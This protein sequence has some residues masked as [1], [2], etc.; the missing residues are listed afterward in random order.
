MDKSATDIGLVQDIR[1]L[2]KLRQLSTGND[3]NQQKALEAAARQFEAIFNQMW[4]GS[5]REANDTLAPDSPLNSRDS[6]FFQGMLDEQRTA[7]MS[8]P[9]SKSSLAQLIVKQL[10]PRQA[11]QAGQTTLETARTLHMPTERVPVVPRFARWQGQ[12]GIANNAGT[13]SANVDGNSRTSGSSSANSALHFERR[14]PTNN[15]NVPAGVAAAERFVAQMDRLQQSGQGSV[16]SQG[17][18]FGSP[19]AFVR[20]LLP[21]AQQVAAKIGLSPVA[22]LAQAALET[23]WGRKMIRDNDGQSANNLFGIKA[24]QR[25][26]GK[27]AQATSLEYE[28]GQPVMRASAF[29]SYDSF[30]QSMEDYVSLIG[31]DARYSQARAV[32]HDPDAYF[33]AL[34]RAGYATDPQYASKLK[35]VLRS[36]AFSGVWPQAAL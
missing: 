21:A 23:G 33:E 30:V 5:M 13:D 4:V 1:G 19:E 7:S 9:N 17:G 35:Q 28:Q 11:H 36:D 10:S 8:S 14:L 32:A 12:N 18:A 16:S 3:T 31:S 27:A 15:S 34:Q 22:L 25:W 29:R 24:G 6:R 20:Q 2:N 26:Q